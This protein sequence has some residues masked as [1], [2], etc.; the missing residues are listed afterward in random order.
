MG[1]G[2]TDAL[3]APMFCKKDGA[4]LKAAVDEDAKGAPT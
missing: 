3:E 2:K 1:V 4:D